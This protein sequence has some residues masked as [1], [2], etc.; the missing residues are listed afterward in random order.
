MVESELPLVG[1]LAGALPDVPYHDTIAVRV[2][3]EITPIANLT[4]RGGYGFETSPIPTTQTGVT[5]LLDGPKHT[6]GAGIGLGWRRA[7]GKAMRLD[8]HVQA[9]LVGA[10]SLSKQIYDPSSGEPY[11]P[12]TSLRDEVTDDPQDPATLGDQISNPGYPGV[13][14]GGQVF[15]AGVTLEIEL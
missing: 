9:Q 15:S 5:N 4:L 2:G 7:G 1:P 13:T 14:S 11:D 3:G 10:R 6:I 8:G 12:Y